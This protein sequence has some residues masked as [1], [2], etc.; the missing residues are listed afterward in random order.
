MC[1]SQRSNA[2]LVYILPYLFGIGFQLNQMQRSAN[3]LKFCN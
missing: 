3:N 2:L 1:K